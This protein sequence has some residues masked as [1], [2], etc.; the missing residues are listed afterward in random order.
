MRKKA[1]SQLLKVSSNT[2]LVQ[3]H[4]SFPLS[5]SYFG[6]LVVAYSPNA[7]V[8]TDSQKVLSSYETFCIPHHEV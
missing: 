7:V 6:Q 1:D 2:I 3:A 5:E 8:S 4:I